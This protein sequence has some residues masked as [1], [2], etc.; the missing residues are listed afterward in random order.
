MKTMALMFVII[1]CC[2]GAA[3]STAQT[4]SHCSAS[5]AA[6]FSCR[7]KGSTKILSL[8]GSKQLSKDTGYLQYRFG[9]PNAV[10]LAFPKE[11]K[12]SLSQFLYFHYFRAQVDRTSV[13]FKNG[14]YK[15]SIYDDYEGEEKP[16]KTD[17][18]VTVDKEETSPTESRDLKCTGPVISRLG[19]LR[20]VIACDKGDGLGDCP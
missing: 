1:I 9:P 4:P 18:G 17:R 3:A 15:Y 16:A 8:C 6:I 12:D 14:G 10:E 13:S 20:E 19:Q 11:K 2:A 7:I 5:E